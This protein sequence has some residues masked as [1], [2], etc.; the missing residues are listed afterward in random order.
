MPDSSSVAR[1]TSLAVK[2]LLA[3][4]G[5]LARV[6]AS[7]KRDPRSILLAIPDDARGHV[8]SVLQEIQARA[9]PGS[10]GLVSGARLLLDAARELW[11]PQ[12]GEGEPGATGQP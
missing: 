1:E 6:D 5:E 7:A 8:V 12:D 11:T 3:R 4:L 2:V 10:E 9:A